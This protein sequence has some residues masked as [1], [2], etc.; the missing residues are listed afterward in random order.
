MTGARV[1]NLRVIANVLGSRLGLFAKD[2][3][4]MGTIE[5]VIIIA[6]LVALALIFKDFIAELAQNL[7]GKIQQNA[8]Q[9]AQ[10]L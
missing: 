4:G 6:V 2:K 5:V 9:A 10:H 1:T 3:R 7:F 8:D